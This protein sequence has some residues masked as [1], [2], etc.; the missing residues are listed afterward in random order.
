MALT[1]QSLKQVHGGSYNMIDVSHL[2]VD[3]LLDH[4]GR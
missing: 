2:R 3:H 4:A 1:R